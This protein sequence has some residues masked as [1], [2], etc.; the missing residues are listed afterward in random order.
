M[1]N[2]VFF[3]LKSGQ[4]LKS[5]AAHPHQEF[6]VVPLGAYS[7]VHIIQ[8]QLNMTF[9]F[10]ICL[11]NV[12]TRTSNKRLN[13]DKMTSLIIMINFLHGKLQVWKISG[14]FMWTVKNLETIKQNIV[15][16]RVITLDKTS[17]VFK[18]RDKNIELAEK[19]RIFKVC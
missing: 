6:P 1:D 18:D 7:P 11:T 14:S 3:G 19:I 13:H 16:N 12:C 10:I 9:Q 17:R 4:D 5:W 15:T 2:Y 8:K